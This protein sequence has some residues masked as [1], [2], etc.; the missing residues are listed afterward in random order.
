MSA[1]GSFGAWRMSSEHS[2]VRR[3]IHNLASAIAVCYRA[4]MHPAVQQQ[5]AGCTYHR[6]CRCRQFCRLWPLQALWQRSRH[7]DQRQTGESTHAAEKACRTES[8][9]ELRGLP[10][11]VFLCLP[12]VQLNGNRGVMGVLRGFDQ[13]MNLVLDGTV[14]T[15]TKADIGMVVRLLMPSLTLTDQLCFCCPICWHFGPAGNKCAT[16]QAARRSVLTSCT[17]GQVVRGNSIVAIEALD[18]A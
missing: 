8:S 7:T 2:A 11:F 12:A 18:S 9:K 6:V 14:D 5:P 15:K 1:T 10:T 13:F 16:I 17:S 3:Q 4:A